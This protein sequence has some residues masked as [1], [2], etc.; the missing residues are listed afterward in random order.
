MT[1]RLGGGEVSLHS[2][3]S[4]DGKEEYGSFIPASNEDVDERLS[5][6]QSRALLL[7]K[8]KE[9]RGRLSEKELDIFDNRI[10]TENPVTLQELGD[11]YS[12]SRE[13]VRQIQEK[14]ITNIKKWLVEEIPMASRNSS[15]PVVPPQSSGGQCLCPPI[16]TGYLTLG[17]GVSLSSTVIRCS[18]SSPRSYRYRKTSPGLTKSQSLCRLSSISFISGISSYS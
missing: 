11:K 4:S 9:Y 14:I 18:Q 13:R 7:D 2:P 15:Y 8:L 1:Q 3:V 6:L 12:I 5:E 10:M 16:Q 17:S